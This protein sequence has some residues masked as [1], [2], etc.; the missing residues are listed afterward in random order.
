[1]ALLRD[2]LIPCVV[3]FF[4]S[5]CCGNYTLIGTMDED[6]WLSDD[7]QWKYERESRLPHD[8]TEELVVRV[9]ASHRNLVDGNV[10]VVYISNDL[11]DTLVNTVE[12]ISG[13]NDCFAPKKI[14]RYLVKSGRIHAVQ[15]PNM[16]PFPDVTFERSVLFAAGRAVIEGGWSVVTIKDWTQPVALKGVVYG[17]CT[18]EVSAFI[19]GND[20]PGTKLCAKK[21]NIC[22]PD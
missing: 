16:E 21:V 1:M 11:N 15:G 8:A 3:C 5:G 13:S 7:L 4:L 9:A 14:V 19:A 20:G 10:T 18:V 22:K 12:D 2:I 6:H 17:K